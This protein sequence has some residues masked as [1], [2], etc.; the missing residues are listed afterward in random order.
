ESAATAGSGAGGQRPTAYAQTVGAAES[1]AGDAGADSAQPHGKP[2]FQ[3]D[4]GTGEHE[5]LSD[6]ARA[7]AAPSR[8]PGPGAERGG[9]RVESAVGESAP[10]DARGAGEQQPHSPTAGTAGTAESEGGSSDP[11]HV[12]AAPAR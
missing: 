7:D 10:A 11:A 3:L 5:S 1:A 2:V 12:Q 8:Q 6:V 4:H 9:D